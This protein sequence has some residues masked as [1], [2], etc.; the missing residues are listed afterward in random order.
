M[1]KPLAHSLLALALLVAAAPAVSA[2]TPTAEKSPLTVETLWKIKRLGAPEISPN[3]KWAA[4]PVTTYDVAKDKGTTNLWLVP[5][6]GGEA[7]RLTT[8]D[9]S[10]SS[11]AWSPDGKWIAFVSRRGED[12]TTQLYL[13][14]TSGGEAWRLTNVP[15]GASAPK[16]FPD[17]KRLAFVS[18][19]WPGL[20]WE[21]MAKRL[22]ERKDS[23]VSAKTWDKAPIRYW[24]TFH[25]DREAH[26]F[27]ISVE[28]GE[29]TAVTVGT[30][31]QLPRSGAGADTYDISPDGKEIAFTA[32]TDRTG[33]DPNPDVYLIAATGGEAK[34]ITAENKAGDTSP[35]YSPDGRWLAF[36]H[37]I[38]K[39][40]YAD[41]ARLVLHDR[42]AGSNKVMTEEWD[43]SVGDLVWTPDSEA[44]YAAIDDAA[45]NRVYRIDAA[46]GKPTAI[47]KDKS[48]SNLA[49]SD[50]GKVL[51]ALR[52]SFSEPPTLVRV[53]TT[54]G[55][56]TKLS[57]FND[58]LLANVAWGRY[59]SV[60]Y[61]GA[62]SADIQMWIIYPPDFDP[63]KKWPFY[64]LLHGGPHN[65]VTDSFHWR[66][67]AQIFSGWGYVTAWH[68]FH[69][70]S[71]FG[72]AF[73]DSINPNQADLPYQ[74]TI[75]AARWFQQQPW[76]DSE[77]MGAGGGSYGGYLATLILGRPHPFKTLVA[78][79]AVYNLYTQVGADYAA[80]KSRFGEYWERKAEFE[81]ISPHLQA[82][83]F[84][85][86]TL[87]IHG[88]RDYR[89][90][91][92]HGVEL[93][94]TLQKRGVKSRLI[95]YPDENHWVLKPQNSI[96]WYN[97]NQKWLKEFLGA[98][99]TP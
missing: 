62:N 90:P 73:T 68:N 54:T 2:Q 52:Q 48:F 46:T 19:V 78:H 51:V 55:A 66:W 10:D 57:T 24:D 91:V 85:T 1:K 56:A 88:E 28:G 83:N 13:I 25:D 47:T 30:K 41:K 82:A 76:I 86:P 33:V 34:N 96:Y 94:N 72:Q 43:R 77:R 27:T 61:K 35:L 32:D 87:I 92:N 42:R 69:G 89:V 45:H 79:A 80:N 8:H 21:E 84:N 12:E 99:P 98:G 64:F 74:D 26:L 37:Q 40:F 59:E 53:D 11:P 50:D 93:F 70:S 14:S 71:G 29:P 65:G 3:G 39:G 6:D 97:E 81:H 67:N 22:K 23:K 75:A 5:T 18:R 95:Y 38:I 31:L 9:G 63:A 58:E 4:V 49:L 17:S 16:W 44:F 15:T 7:R 20:K 36:E 60:T